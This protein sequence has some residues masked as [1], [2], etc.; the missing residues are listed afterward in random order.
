M[1]PSLLIPKKAINQKYGFGTFLL[2]MEIRLPLLIY[3]F[4]AIKYLGQISTVLFSDFGFTW[5]QKLPNWTEEYWDQNNNEGFIWTYGFGPRFIFL[6]LPWK[7][8]YAWQINPYNQE[9]TSRS[10]FLTIGLDF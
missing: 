2:N 6:G 5:N 7:L 9:N 10:W 1:A 4:P 3:Y 8:D